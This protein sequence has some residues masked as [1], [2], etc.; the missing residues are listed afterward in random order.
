ML[1]FV[2]TFFYLLKYSE[3][4]FLSMSQFNWLTTPNGGGGRGKYLIKCLPGFIFFV[5]AVNY[6][7][8]VCFLFFVFFWP[9]FL[10]DYNKMS[11]P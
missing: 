8:V 5:V 1:R 4:F 6:G 9:V 3:F 7:V 11:I 10:L 2:G